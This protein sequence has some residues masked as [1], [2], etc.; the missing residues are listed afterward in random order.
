MTEDTS[1]APKKLVVFDVEGVL[2]PKYRYLTFEVGRNLSIPQFVK[3]LFAGF[4]YHVGLISLESA[5]KRIFKLLRSITVEELLDIFRKVPLLPHV[6]EVFAE[7]NARGFKTALISSGLPQVV[8]ENLALRLKADHA[9]G[10]EL[11][12]KGSVLTGNIK[13]DVIKE[14]GK[15]LVMQRVLHQ[16]KLKVADCIVVADDRNNSP[17]FYEDAL[18]IG[19]NPD[20]VIVM[21]SDHVIRENLLEIIPIL[22]RTQQSP[23]YSLS[24]NEAIREIIHAG[25]FFVA[26]LAAQRGEV[27]LVAFLLSLTA[28]L[29]TAS[30]LARID[31]K[32]VPLVSLITFS[33]ATASERFEFAT[34]PI[35]LALGITLSLLLFPTPA[36]YASIAIVSLGDSAA[37]VFGKLFGK[38]P[39]PF[40][41]GK[42]LEGSLAGFAFA[43]L[44]AAYFL[45]PLQALIGAIA[46]M[47]VESLPLPIS[48]NLST[49]LITGAL[50]TGLQ[51]I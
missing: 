1:A 16:E 51:G 6:E 40:N 19:Y 7:L 46:G 30:E 36:S 37:S 45:N 39:L 15:A 5:L 22:E 32:K 33:A 17:I 2:L 41:K 12:I 25:G 48:D 28:L 9:Y 8:V 38:T 26:L 21:K 20:F 44:G 29:Y 47:I 50:L 27:V 43:Y 13:G 24:R 11:D 4:L 31:R 3:I 23:G 18:K 10:L 14:R 35:F 34:S 42:N 49:P